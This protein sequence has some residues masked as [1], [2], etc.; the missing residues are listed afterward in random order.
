MRTIGVVT[1]ARADFD[2]YLPVLRGIKAAPDLSLHLIVSGMHLS[3][4]F[5]CTETM[6]EAAGFDIGQRVEMLVSSDRPGGIVRSM[7]LGLIG[8]AQAFEDARPDMLLVLGDRFEMHAAVLAA[9]PFKLPVAH[10]HGGEVTHG[11]IDDALRHSIT[12]LSHLHFVATEVYAR[13][14]EQLGEEPWRITVSGAPALDN[15]REVALL[16]AKELEVTYGIRVD[17]RPLLVTFHPVTLEYEQSARQV[18]ALLAALEAWGGPVVFTQ[19]NADTSGREINRLLHAW[20]DSRDDAWMLDNLG[21]RAY[22]SMMAQAA[23][24][25]GN[26][27]SGLIEAPSF[28]LP[29]VNI[30][31]RQGGR[32]RASNVIDVGYEQAEIAAAISEATS[33]AFRDGLRYLVNPYGDGGAAARIVA[34]LSAAVLDDRLLLKVFHDSTG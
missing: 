23:A 24:M 22:F 4:E 2:I 13:R 12:K 9:L 10:I 17:P 11:A 6:I 8:Y 26:S 18:G 5:G 28:R 15:L 27:S 16:P 1:T 19:A 25:V 30:G 34:G 20:V 31:S 3:P 7:G 21:N 14:V 33:E 32:L 29:V